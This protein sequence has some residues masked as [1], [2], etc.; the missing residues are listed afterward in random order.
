M[1]NTRRASPASKKGAWARRESSS[2]TVVG[3]RRW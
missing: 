2:L 1:L 3:E